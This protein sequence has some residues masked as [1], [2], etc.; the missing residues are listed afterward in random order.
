MEDFKISLAAARVNAGLSQ[1]ELAD[2]MNVSRFTI[3]NWE[4]GK[5]KIGT[6]QLFLF[7]ELCGIPRKYIFL[8]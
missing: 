1:K 7:C 8:P 3:C 5:V 4:S 6:A 2:K